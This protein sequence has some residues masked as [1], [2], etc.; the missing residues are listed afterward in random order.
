MQRMA[1]T[2][3]IRNRRGPARERG[4]AAVLAMMFL[5]IFSSLATAMAIVSQGNLRTADSH[6]RMTS[7]MAAADSGSRY[8]MF[9]LDDIIRNNPAT[10]ATP[11]GE[12][13]GSDAV[14]LWR[15]LTAEL[16][17]RLSTTD[18]GYESFDSGAGFTFGPVKVG[19]EDQ[20]YFLVTLY[21][22]WIPTPDE[23]SGA[24]WERNLL[25]GHRYL[26]ADGRPTPFYNRQPYTAE[27]PVEDWE[28]DLRPKTGM[29]E[30][31]SASNDR[32]DPRYV[33]LVVQGISGGV[34][35]SDND[36]YADG[37][38]PN[39]VCRTLSMDLRITKRLRSAILSKSRVQI[40][41]NVMVRGNIGSAFTDVH[42]ENGHPIQMESDFGGL[43]PD[44]DAL[45]DGYYGTLLADPKID[46]DGDNRVNLASDGPHM[47]PEDLEFLKRVDAAG[48]GDGFVDDF[49]LFMDHFDSN[50]DR[51]VDV[52]EMMSGMNPAWTEDAR[53]RRA[54]QLVELIDTF[55][56]DYH[57]NDRGVIDFG[58]GYAKIRGT[59]TFRTTL[60]EWEDGAA[61]GNY[62]NDFQGPVAPKRGDD[63]TRFG[64]QDFGFVEDEANPF[65]RNFGVEDY[66][67]IATQELPAATKST[68]APEPVPYDS[69][70]PYDHYD[71]PVYEDMTFTNV[72][73]PLGTNALFKRCVFRGV[74]YVETFADN[75]L[76]HPYDPDANAFNYS[77]MQERD[78][79]PKHPDLDQQI[80][81]E[82]RNRAPNGATGTTKDLGNNIRFD[83]C[84]FEG[85]V[86]S[87]PKSGSAGQQP[88]KYSHTRNKLT[89]T[90][91][92]GPT[93]FP[94]VDDLL[95]ENRISAEQWDLY[96]RGRIITPHM[97]VEMG[98]FDGGADDQIDL[99]GVVVAGVLDLRGRVKVNGSIITTYEPKA[100][101]GTVMGDTS[102]QF[103]T[104]LGY[105]G[106]DKGDLETDRPAD[107]DG[108]G[109]I[110]V[111]YDPTLPMPNGIRMSISLERLESTYYEGAK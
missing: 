106:R 84:R 17:A 54:E 110:Q 26:D 68:D 72:F 45:L 85:P 101:D 98:S 41:R 27:A 37:P 30:P 79:S 55:I 29:Y 91:E 57:E 4:A 53:L 14:P 96:R 28:K 102:P 42:L 49:E 86:V 111:R 65:Q 34:V 80:R 10:F 11:T 105:F 78:G 58:D 108:W 8:A 74:T 51:R 67:D 24:A 3:P 2:N 21:Q 103:N 22:H 13:S 7:A 59:V 12:I 95:K 75:D 83:S 35:D 62:R 36:G 18:I 92:N 90:S 9:L 19:P 25:R 5:V 52:V 56:P 88:L 43:H 73:I 1:A 70:Y 99:S 97:S 31:I 81:T 109:M 60:E 44:L 104:T 32:L 39:A 94:N 69:A 63:A 100:G 46:A 87:G 107:D 38:A 47:A 89:F 64:V 66:A 6:L 16:A 77:G 23:Q 40:G 15:D 50:G 93:E 61:D 71:R 33:R 20:S 82:V 76:S 48:N